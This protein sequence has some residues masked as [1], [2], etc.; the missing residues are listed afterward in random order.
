MEGCKEVHLAK[1]WSS[2]GEGL[3]PEWLSCLVKFFNRPG[4]AGA[5]L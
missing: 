1:G 5:V 4:V 2:N 3:L